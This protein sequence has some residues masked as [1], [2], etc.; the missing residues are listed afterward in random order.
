[1]RSVALARYASEGCWS[2]MKNTVLRA[3]IEITFI[4]FLFYSNLMMGEYERSGIGLKLGLAG[5]VRDVF[6]ASNFAIAAGAA[7]VGYI[8]FESLRKKF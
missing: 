7:L 3:L 6:T 5:A 8:V 4:I 2:P 1:L